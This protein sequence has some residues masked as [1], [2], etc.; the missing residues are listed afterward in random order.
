MELHEASCAAVSA[1]PGAP[2]GVPMPSERPGPKTPRRQRRE[3]D[4]IAERS[5]AEQLVARI[6]QHRQA[7]RAALVVG[8]LELAFDELLAARHLEPDLDRFGALAR[9]C[10]PAHWE[11]ETDLTPLA[12]ALSARTHPRAADAW[13]ELL[14]DGP[15]RSIQAE[16]A[17]WLARYAFGAGHARLGLR[18]LH[19]ASHLGRALESSAFVAA[20][21]HAGID[22]TGAFGLY[23]AATRLDPGSARAAGLRDPLTDQLWPDQDARWW[24]D[25]ARPSPGAEASNPQLEALHR[26]SDLAQTKRDH[27][28]LL[29]AEADYLAGPLGVRTLGRNIRAGCAESAEHDTFVRIR[30]AYESAADRLSDVAWPWYRLA[31]LLAWAGFFERATEHL[32]QA[33][34]RS[35]GSREAERTQRPMLRALVQAGLGSGPDGLPTAARPFPAA[36]F[37]PSLASR[38]RLF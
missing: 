7:G 27:G 32:A 18:R 14:E 22:P 8:E 23:L 35:L 20:Y 26:A 21:K 34:R 9:D 29:L 24:L 38:F 3:R 2:A 25:E 12:R 19:A 33:E 36:P 13:R 37:S 17:E 10:L 16:A 15:A 28:W 31:E 30:L 4:P 5:H 11:L 6:S 1:L